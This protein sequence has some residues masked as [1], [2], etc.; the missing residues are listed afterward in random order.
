MDHMRLCREVVVD[1]RLVGAAWN[2]LRELVLEWKA[3]LLPTIA[4]AGRRGRGVARVGLV[5]RVLR[6]DPHHHGQLPLGLVA[7]AAWDEAVLVVQ[8]RGQHRLDNLLA[9][10]AVERG[11]GGG[12]GGGGGGGHVR[13]VREG[14]PPESL[15]ER[16]RNV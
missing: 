5:A 11:R 10:G 15:L 14:S 7:G 9:D 13:A 16:L 4:E 12:G 8:E 6:L 2:A 1:V 3:H